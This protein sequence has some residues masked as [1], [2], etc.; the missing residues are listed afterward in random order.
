MEMHR[1][2]GSPATLSGSPDVGRWLCVPPFRA[3][4]PFQVKASGPREIAQHVKEYV[5]NQFGLKA[6]FTL[7]AHSALSFSDFYRDGP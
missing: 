1:S 7:S 4:C 3:V 5:E 6:S 2:P